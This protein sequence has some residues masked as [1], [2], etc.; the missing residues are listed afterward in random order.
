MFAVVLAGAAAALCSSSDCSGFLNPIKTG[1]EVEGE[2]RVK[3]K[4]DKLPKVIITIFCMVSVGQVVGILEFPDHELAFKALLRVM[5]LSWSSVR[6]CLGWRNLGVIQTIKSQ[7][8]HRRWGRGD[9]CPDPVTA[10][11]SEQLPLGLLPLA[12]PAW[13]VR[14]GGG[15][16]RGPHCQVL[17]HTFLRQNPR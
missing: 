7:S 9:S 14:R 16:C 5:L 12:P 15:S 8:C 10:R 2:G 1:G 4:A 6:G 11:L 3:K 17:T 13:P